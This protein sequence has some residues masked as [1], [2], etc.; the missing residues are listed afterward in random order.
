MA[1]FHASKCLLAMLKTD[2]RDT[3]I[4]YLQKMLRK[5]LR[6][7]FPS[8]LVLGLLFVSQQLNLARKKNAELTLRPPVPPPVSAFL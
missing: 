8:K 7:I 5:S 6:K 3:E 1:L 2:L 4:A